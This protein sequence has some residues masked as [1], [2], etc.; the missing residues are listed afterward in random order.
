M[1][2]IPDRPLVVLSCLAKATARPSPVSRRFPPSGAFSYAV[3]GWLS[4]AA[5][6]STSSTAARHLFAP[7]P[8]ET[9]CRHR[10]HQRRPS[11]AARGFGFGSLGFRHCATVPLRYS[12]RP[13]YTVLCPD[14]VDPGVTTQRPGTGMRYME[15]REQLRRVLA[16]SEPA[17]MGR[18]GVIGD[19]GGMNGQPWA[20]ESPDSAGTCTMD[21]DP[22]DPLPRGE[23]R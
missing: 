13:A 12:A 2:G 23:P 8:A 9:R 6:G 17:F 14:L 16:R 20:V 19:E 5:A 15:M 21:S 3:R 10:C 22:N 7:V 11:T 4:P 1:R 18:L